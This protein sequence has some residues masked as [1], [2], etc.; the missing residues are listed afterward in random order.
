MKILVS[1]S[2]IVSTK[3]YDTDTL[4]VFHPVQ[5]LGTAKSLINLITK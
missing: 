5:A 3:K 4:L 1:I 2:V